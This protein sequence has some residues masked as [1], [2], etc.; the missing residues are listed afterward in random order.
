MQS[1]ATGLI[2][3]LFV[4]V[5]G[6]A[7]ACSSSSSK[8]ASTDDAGATTM[9]DGGA[10]VGPIEGLAES[11]IAAFNAGLG[12]FLHEVTPSEGIGPLYTNES[13]A[14]CHG[15]S[16]RGPGFAT[17][18]A[19][20]GSDGIT[21]T[22]D[23]SLLPFGNT[24]HPKVVAGTGAQTPIGLPFEGTKDLGGKD[25][26]VSVRVTKLLGP[27]LFGRGYL[28]AI[29]DSEIE[30]MEAQQAPRTDG[31]RGRA[32]R[33]PFASQPNPNPT[34]DSH[35]PGDMVIGRFGLKARIATLDEFSADALQADMGVTSPM[36]PME[37]PNP[38]GVTDDLKVGVDVTADQMNA[39]AQFIR[40][41]AIPPRTPKAA[42]GRAWFENCGC[43][44]CHTASLHT[45]PDYPIKQLADIDVAVYTDMLL[46]DMGD[47]LA[48]GISRGNEGMAGPRDWRTAPLVGVMYSKTLLHDGRATTVR[49]AILMHGGPK[50]EGE[51]AAQCF[52]GLAPQFQQQILD[53]VESL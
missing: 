6:V 21:P 11:D 1:P 53:F 36:R 14:A 12:E 23:Q 41:L 45:R 37:F 25:G 34:F 5:S 3:G 46:H 31:I 22:D 50:S 49:D 26:T 51:A 18:M 43:H 35:K 30:R 20:V 52:G 15:G 7:A 13:C 42:N 48:D 24:Q 8:S 4:V 32:N 27:P 33:L 16:A 17:K 2:L 40:L 10:G 19:I 28:E 38:D 29:A 47:N 9:L 39:R 44:I